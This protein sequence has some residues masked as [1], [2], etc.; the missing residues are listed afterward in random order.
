[1]NRIWVLL[2][3]TG[4]GVYAGETVSAPKG[5]ASPKLSAQVKKTM[6][7]FAAMD[8]E[9]FEAGLA[10]DV[11]AFE[12]DM[13]GKPVR[14]GSHGEVVRFARETFAQLKKMG[15][16]AK[17]DFHATDCRETAMLAYC[18]VEFDFNATMPDGSAM[19]QPTRN[20]IL[21][22]KVGAGWKWAHWH[23]SLAVLPAAP[24]PATAP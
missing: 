11:T 21:L 22:R 24:A 7:A 15:A 17:L 4:M 12:I 18:T 6:D 20:T 13:D 2:L 8:L 1:M 14:L 5:S 3:A 16:S 23:S 10:A 9:G 19:S